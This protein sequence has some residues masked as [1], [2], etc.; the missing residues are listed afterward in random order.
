MKQ[1]P[2]RMKKGDK[3][4]M[5]TAEDE[6]DLVEV[7]VNLVGYSEHSTYKELVAFVE[8][9]KPVK[10]TPTVYSSEEKRKKITDDFNKYCD[11]GAAKEKFLSSFFGEG[12]SGGSKSSKKHQ[13]TAV[14]KLSMSSPPKPSCAL[15]LVPSEDDVALITSMGFSASVAEAALAFS[16]NNAQRAVEYLLSSSSPPHQTPQKRQASDKNSPKPPPKREKTK[17]LDSFFLRPKK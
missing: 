5:K 13:A 14:S 8:G 2:R 16:K 17:T 15:P 6:N 3:G 12:G 1:V 9:L 10:V 11:R 4:V 7:T